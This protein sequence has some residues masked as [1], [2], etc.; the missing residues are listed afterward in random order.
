MMDG[1]WSWEN[2]I[3]V[4]CWV[5]ES[6]IDELARDLLR[7]ATEKCFFGVKNRGNYL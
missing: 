2:C 1:I 7:S 5:G 4:D 6:I 3:V